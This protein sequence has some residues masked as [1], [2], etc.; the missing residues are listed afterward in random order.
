MLAAFA[1]ELA[2]LGLVAH[3]MTA[4][5][6]NGDALDLRARAADRRPPIP[7]PAQIVRRQ[8]PAVHEWASEP[9]T[10][11]G[12]KI[13][14]SPDQIRGLASRCAGLDGLHYSLAQLQRTWLRHRSASKTV[15]PDALIQTIPGNADSTQVKST[16][17][18]RMRI[19]G[20]SGLCDCNGACE[21]L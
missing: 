21:L 12:H 8:V 14:S 3:P 13:R 18:A 20:R 15:P 6:D 19:V 5:H 17:S 10:A 7:S 1:N 9:V 11:S 16:L 2:A 4:R